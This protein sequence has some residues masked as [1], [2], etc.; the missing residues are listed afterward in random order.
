M[1]QN[2]KPSSA[3]ACQLWLAADVWPTRAGRVVAVASAGMAEAKKTRAVGGSSGDPHPGGRPSTALY[4][5]A[6]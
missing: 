4:G 3:P 1:G 5:I 6:E 2:P